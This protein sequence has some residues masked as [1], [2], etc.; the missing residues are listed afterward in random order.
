MKTKNALRPNHSQLRL[1]QTYQNTGERSQHLLRLL[2]LHNR[3][4]NEFAKTTIGQQTITDTRY[5]QQALMG[6]KHTRAPVSEESALCTI[7]TSLTNSFCNTNQIKLVLLLVDKQKLMKNKKQRQRSEQKLR[8]TNTKTNTQAYRSRGVDG[9]FA[10]AI[11]GG[12]GERVVNYLG[13]NTTHPSKDKWGIVSK[14]RYNSRQHQ[15]TLPSA[16]NS[17]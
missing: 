15:Q 4:T 12:V 16:H 13:C 9:R 10:C 17:L 2:N 14:D 6:Y 5:R 3:T 11:V 1:Q 8:R 7:A